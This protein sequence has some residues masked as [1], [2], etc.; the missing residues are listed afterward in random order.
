MKRQPHVL[1]PVPSKIFAR[2]LNPVKP[3]S[4]N[5]APIKVPKQPSEHKTFL[6]FNR[7]A[8]TETEKKFAHHCLVGVVIKIG[9]MYQ[10]SIPLSLSHS[11]PPEG[12]IKAAKVSV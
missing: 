3:R 10:N 12:E 7:K 11:P 4:T 1:G 2:A 6:T 9:L 8:P 5:S